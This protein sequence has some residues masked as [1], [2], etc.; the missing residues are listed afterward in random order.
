MSK[1]SIILID[2]NSAPTPQQAKVPTTFWSDNVP[3]GYNKDDIMIGE[4]KVYTRADGKEFKYFYTGHRTASEMALVD[5]DVNFTTIDADPDGDTQVNFK[6]SLEK[7]LVMVK[8]H[9]ELYQSVAM[10][11]GEFVPVKG[12]PQIIRFAEMLKENPNIKKEDLNRNMPDEAFDKLKEY[13]ELYNLALEIEQYTDLVVPS[14]NKIHRDAGTT[15]LFAH[16]PGVTS[17][18]VSKSGDVSWDIPKDCP[19]YVL[20]DDETDVLMPPSTPAAQSSPA[21]IRGAAELARAKKIAPNDPRIQKLQ[22]RRG[23]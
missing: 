10:P 4:E 21:T 13:A 11:A 20:C 5:L 15:N 6:E 19:D 9:P 2:S 8:E 22:D 1:P 3:K 18:S 7:T 23:Q 17:V 12:I 16:V 14:G